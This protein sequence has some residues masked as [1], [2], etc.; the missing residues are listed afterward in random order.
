MHVIGVEPSVDALRHV[1]GS[2]SESEQDQLLDWFGKH[3]G[4]LPFGHGLFA[5]VT[6]IEAL[7]QVWRGTA[8]PLLSDA[9]GSISAAFR[10]AHDDFPFR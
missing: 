1:V 9:S 10:E 4:T 3:V 5:N 8:V 7:T 6:S 2:L